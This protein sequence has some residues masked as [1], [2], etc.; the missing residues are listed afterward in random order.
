MEIGHPVLFAVA[1]LV[2]I[3]FVRPLFRY[4]FRDWGQMLE[5]AGLSTS[6]DRWITGYFVALSG[7]FRSA[8]FNLNLIG[9]VVTLAAICALFYNILA[10][11]SGWVR[12]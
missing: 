5:D 6:D 4:F 9:F 12:S 3:A 8:H 1:A 11:G 10:I 2:T 7:W